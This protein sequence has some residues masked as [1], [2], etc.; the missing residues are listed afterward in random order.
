MID[1]TLFFML[2]VGLVIS[3]GMLF[4][5]IW[6]A[7]S[8]QFDDASKMT[9]G[10]LFDSVEDLND[11]INYNQI[12]EQL[13]L[14]SLCIYSPINYILP[15][16]L[17]KY[18]DTS[19]N[20]SVRFVAGRE[21]GIKRLT[22]IN[23]MKRMESSV[24][25]FNLTLERI[26]QLIGNTISAIKEFEDEGISKSPLDLVDISEIDEFDYD[27]QNTNIFSVG[28]KVK[29]KIEDMDY[30]TW[31]IELEKDKETL[32]LLHLMIADITPNHDSKLQTLISVIEEKIKHPINNDNKKLIIF[33]AFADTAEYL[34]NNISNFVKQKFSLNTAMVTG[35]IEGRTTIP[36]IKSDLNTVLTCFSPISKGKDL[37]M[38]GNEDEIDILIATDCISEGQNLQDCD[39]LINYDIHW[40]PVRIIQRFGRIDRIGSKNECIQLVNFWPDISLDE[41]I[42]LKSR[43]ETRMKIVDMTATGDDNIL[44]DEEKG[45]LEYRKQ[46]LMRL[47]EEVVDIE[48]MSSGIS[49]MD[50]GLNEFRLDLLD[51]AKRNPELDKIPFGM[52]AV[53]PSNSETPP[54][55]LFVL[56]N[57]N[58]SINIDNQNILH[59]FYMVY[60][61]DDGDIVFDHLSPK[62][63][64]DKMRYI[65]KGKTTPIA[66]LC[67]KFNEETKD[68]RDM[69]QFSGLL[70]EAIT[71]IIQVKEDSELDSFLSG[72]QVSFLSN[73]IKGL[74]DFELI[75]FLVVKSGE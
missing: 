13:M 24:Y 69:S 2:V 30:I 43:V 25:S 74:D 70:G 52:H 6:A 12:F 9:N 67:K 47:Q 59:P 60:I 58:G 71:S 36:K 37:L 14:L 55:V 38:P 34:Y 19:T 63:M 4:L 32:E 23:L 40:N 26:K 54:G 8:G 66:D 42:N 31:K 18:I 68:G 72:G 22:A 27:D 75:C 61:S 46:Q 16:K 51:Y 45:D 21:E 57:I 28:R 3:A 73:T 29:I 64:L 62:N 41:Y 33:T 39:Y 50:L 15:S 56:K 49:I 7:K 11:A 44:S 53:V 35:S 48:D 17:D 5:F 65:C 20:Q 10:M 1:D